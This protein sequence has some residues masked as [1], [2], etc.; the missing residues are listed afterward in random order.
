MHKNLAAAY[1]AKRKARKMADGGEANPIWPP[2]A[3]REYQEPADD[4]PM[5]GPETSPIDLAAMGA[6][7]YAANAAE[8]AGAAG[9]ALSHEDAIGKL[10]DRV[11]D[12][13]PPAP[14]AEMPSRIKAGDPEYGTDTLTAERSDVD[15]KAPKG[16]KVK[17]G[18]VSMAES[19]A[20]GGQAGDIVKMVMRRRQGYPNPQMLD[21]G[22]MADD[23]VDQGLEADSDQAAQD[24]MNER[25]Q[26][27]QRMVLDQALEKKARTMKPAQPLLN[28]PRVNQ[29]EAER[30]QESEK[31]GSIVPGHASGGMISRIMAKRRGN[32]IQSMSHD[33]GHQDLMSD[34]HDLSPFQED[35][36]F[37]PDEED[38]NPKAK[39]KGLLDSIM[40][41]LHNKHY[42]R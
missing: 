20:N 26:E 34:E 10:K 40:Q 37:M 31:Q 2:R 22:G 24:R 12:T 21:D 28:D 19:L 32:Q 39:R 1:S 18:Q 25:Q 30:Q 29:R 5:D 27:K 7:G 4:K 35:H 14:K 3:V 16:G 33:T 9:E 6:A 13:P 8:G 41:G 42:G 38:D 36:D 15:T 23:Q 17:R 11:R